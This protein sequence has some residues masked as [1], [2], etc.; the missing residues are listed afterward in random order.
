MK[1]AEFRKKIEADLKAMGYRANTWFWQT[2]PARLILILNGEPKEL[3]IKANMSKIA[4]ARILGKL[5][6]WADFVVSRN[7]EPVKTVF[8]GRQIDLEDAIAGAVA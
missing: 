8:H 1:R 2:N 6:G 5:E 3:P 4:L 7:V